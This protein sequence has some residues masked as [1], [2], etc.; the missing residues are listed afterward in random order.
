[1]EQ[2]FTSTFNPGSAYSAKTKKRFL[3]CQQQR[4]EN[5]GCPLSQYHSSFDAR[6]YGFSKLS[7]LA[8]RCQMRTATRNFRERG[9]FGERW[10]ETA[11]EG[12]H[13]SL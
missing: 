6:N 1:M 4:V 9:E 13:V 5:W 7:D 8:G 2:S 3:K 10:R 11:G 12:E